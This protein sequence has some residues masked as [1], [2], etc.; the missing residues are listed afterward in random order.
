MKDNLPT[1]QKLQL[2]YMLRT[3]SMSSI[4]NPEKQK[5]QQGLSR[6][7]DPRANSASLLKLTELNM[8]S[9]FT[10]G[11]QRIDQNSKKGL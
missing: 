2:K 5:Q 7:L 4:V 6:A 8:K 11:G 9:F 10:L 1:H 3:L